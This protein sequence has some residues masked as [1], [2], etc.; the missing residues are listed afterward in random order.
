MIVNPF[1]R[2]EENLQRILQKN[3]CGFLESLE[4]FNN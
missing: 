1:L 3:V 2:W 4:V